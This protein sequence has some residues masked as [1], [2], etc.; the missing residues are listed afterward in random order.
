[1]DF[2]YSTPGGAID[3]A[4]TAA[5]CVLALIAG[6]RG[7]A[8]AVC[9]LAVF[10]ADRAVMHA[11]SVDL[12]PVC[13]ALVEFAAVCG[14]LAAVPGRVGRAMAALAIAKMGVYALTIGAVIDRDA[15]ANAATVAVYLQ[16][17]LVLAGVYGGGL[18]A[19]LRPPHRPGPADPRGAAAVAERLDAI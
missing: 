3:A 11:V 12:W 7:R 4:V 17:M 14:I 18:F 13:G 6:G 16:L 15:M 2:F 1:M 10:L 5:V 9:V 8:L 19:R